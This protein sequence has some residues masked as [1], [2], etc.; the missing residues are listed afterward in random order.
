MGMPRAWRGRRHVGG[1]LDAE[2]VEAACG[3]MLQ[4][5]AVVAGDLHDPAAGAEAEARTTSSQYRRACATQLSEYDEK[6]A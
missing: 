2:H 1:R 4:E 5:I 6:Y 3:E